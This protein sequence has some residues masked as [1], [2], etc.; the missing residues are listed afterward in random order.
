MPP[1]RQQPTPKGGDECMRLCTA[2]TY[3]LRQLQVLVNTWQPRRSDMPSIYLQVVVTWCHHSPGMQK[4]SPTSVA[5][6]CLMVARV[7]GGS[8]TRHHDMT[9]HLLEPQP[10]YPA[11]PPCSTPVHVCVTFCDTSVTHLYSCTAVHICDA[12]VTHLYSCTA[13][14]SCMLWV[15]ERWSSSSAG[16]IDMS[17]TGAVSTTA[18]VR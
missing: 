5:M 7:Q 15:H 14:Q 1:C 6:T 4:I 3:W 13:V 12:S 9:R 11:A 8:M 2:M 16:G 10:R 18:L 17:A